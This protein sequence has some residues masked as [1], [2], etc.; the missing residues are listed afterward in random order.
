MACALGTDARAG[1]GERLLSRARWTP[2]V[3][4][5]WALPPRVPWL[6]ARV[7]GAACA[8]LAPHWAHAYHVSDELD[9]ARLSTQ[10][11]LCSNLATLSQW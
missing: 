1:S 11:A 10:Q 2:S 6:L 9:L 8:I 4:G 3:A 7:L 5:A